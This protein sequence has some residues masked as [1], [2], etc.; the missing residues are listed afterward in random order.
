MRRLVLGTRGSALALRQAEIV[1]DALRAAGVGVELDVR[2]LAT[3]GDIERDIPLSAFGER[4]IF[5][6][7]IEDALRR[8]EID[9]AVHSAKDLPAEL[10]ADL[11][12]AAVLPRAD[13]RDVLV[14]SGRTLAE[15]PAGAT[16]GTSSARRTAQLRAARPDVVVREMRG[17]VDVRLESLRR[18]EHDAIV[19]AAAG[20]IR[21]GLG[22]VISEWLPLDVVLPAPGQ[23]ALAIEVRAG[24]SR[25]TRLLAPLTDRDTF[26]AVVAER[27]LLASFGEACAVAVAGH[28]RSIAS[29]LLELTGLAA[30]PDGRSVRAVRHGPRHS[31]AALGRAVAADLRDAGADV[32]LQAAAVEA[33]GA[34]A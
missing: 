14:S 26:D 30:A 31:A 3:R 5:A 21:L 18:G 13:V 32:L 2:V 24:A 28:A 16:I 20:L 17:N 23:G 1:G 8:G 33:V 27:A 10:P 11:R 12:I 6:D 29:G 7:A 9:L 22:H 4:G 19:L 34:E 15:L 25:L